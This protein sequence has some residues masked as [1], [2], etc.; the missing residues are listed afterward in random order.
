[1]AEGGAAGEHCAKPIIPPVPRLHELFG[2]WGNREARGMKQVPRQ[3]LV[4]SAA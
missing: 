4:L 2:P 3:M 1:V